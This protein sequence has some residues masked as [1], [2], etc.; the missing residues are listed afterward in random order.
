MIFSSLFEIRR[1]D[2]YGITFKRTLLH[3]NRVRYTFPRSCSFVF[4]CVLYKSWRAAGD[5]GNLFGYFVSDTNEEP[6]NNAHPQSSIIYMYIINM[7]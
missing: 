3:K 7:T 1:K 5:W 6:Y 4:L 2:V